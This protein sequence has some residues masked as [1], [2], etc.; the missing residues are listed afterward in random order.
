MDTESQS[1]DVQKKLTSKEEDRLLT[2]ILHFGR[3]L[4]ALKQQLT[5]EY[6]ENAHHEKMLQ[7]NVHAVPIQGNV[8]LRFVSQDA[9][10]LLAY[11]DAKLSPL[12]H[13]L[14]PSQRESISSILNSAI[15]GKSL[16]PLTFRRSI[17]FLVEA[18]NMPR[19]PALEVLAGYLT[20]CDKLMH[21]NSIPDC[22]FIDLNKY[23]R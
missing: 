5:H 3:E 6:G 10:S 4:H 8:L 19:H 13:L 21:K 12:A 7:V 14:E 1:S 23:L 11:P 2:N 16:S 9:Y 20:E 22:A 17:H 18:H 15:L